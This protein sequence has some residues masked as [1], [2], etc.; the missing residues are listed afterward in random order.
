MHNYWC[1]RKIASK[2]T[3]TAGQILE[4]IVELIITPAS[5]AY[6][7]VVKKIFVE[8]SAIYSMYT[9]TCRASATTYVVYK[10]FTSN[11]LNY[12]LLYI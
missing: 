12:Y 1:K 5:V 11:D 4:N 6:Y 2:G 10:C 9:L 7:E 3:K 8:S